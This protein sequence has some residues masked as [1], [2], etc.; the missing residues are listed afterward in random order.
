MSCHVERG[1][2]GRFAAKAQT[3]TVVC[4][5]CRVVRT[6]RLVSPKP[7]VC[8]GCAD[9]QYSPKLGEQAHWMGGVLP[10]LCEECN[11]GL[12]TGVDG[13]C[14][15]CRERRSAAENRGKCAEVIDVRDRLTIDIDV[16]GTIRIVVKI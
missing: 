4:S 16:H 14:H 15:G 9:R 5:K 8:I 3:E 12:L 6:A 11:V 1:K 13:L 7:F 10:K 2:D